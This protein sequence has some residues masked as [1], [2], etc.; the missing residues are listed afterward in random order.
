MELTKQFTF[1]RKHFAV[2]FFIGAIL[3]LFGGFSNSGKFFSIPPATA[4]AHSGILGQPAPALNLHDWIDGNGK[5]ME[6][7]R[8]E[9]YRGKVIYLYFFQDW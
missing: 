6:P 4:E 7:V 8:V 9:D 1:I 3:I 5:K 2:S